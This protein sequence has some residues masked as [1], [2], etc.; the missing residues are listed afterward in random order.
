MATPMDF[1]NFLQ[2]VAIGDT[3]RVDLARS[4]ARKT[5]TVV[6]TGYDRADVRILLDPQATERQRRLRE[7]WMSGGP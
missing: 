6:V 1:R 5:V 4:S 2:R 3:V 7:R